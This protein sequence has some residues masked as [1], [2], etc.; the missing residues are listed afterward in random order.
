LGLDITFYDLLVDHHVPTDPGDSNKLEEKFWWKHDLEILPVLRDRVQV[1]QC[2]KFV[3]HYV[4]DHLL[5]FLIS[6]IPKF[7]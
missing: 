7:G 1:P 5:G 4:F 6:G 3:Q 2:E